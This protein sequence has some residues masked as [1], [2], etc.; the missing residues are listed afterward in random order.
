MMMVGIDETLRGNIMN[1]GRYRGGAKRSFLRLHG[2]PGPRN[3]RKYHFQGAQAALQTDDGR[4]ATPTARPLRQTLV[5]TKWRKQPINS[6]SATVGWLVLPATLA[7]A[8]A[9]ET[10]KTTATE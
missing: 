5:G 2:P 10:A 7:A 4:Y 8:V 9:A 6:I 3:H 1:D